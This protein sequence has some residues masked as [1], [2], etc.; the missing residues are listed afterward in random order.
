MLQL[1]PLQHTYLSS[2]LRLAPLHCC[3]CSC[4]C[5]VVLTSPKL[6]AR[7]LQ[8]DFTL[9]FHSTLFLV[10]HLLCVTPQSWA[11]SCHPGYTATNGLSWPLTR[12][13]LAA[14]HDPVMPSN[15]CHLGDFY[16]LLSPATNMRY[17][18]GYLC[19]TA[20]LCSQETLPRRFHLSDAGVFLITSKECQLS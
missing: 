3:C 1:C 14:L 2:G 16:T 12:L 13:A 9:T 19:N 18:L 5:F 8:L 10:P 4:G 6:L 15:P 20:S 7:L 11:F 17:N